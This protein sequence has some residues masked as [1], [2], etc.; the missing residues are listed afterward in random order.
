M[1]VSEKDLEAYRATCRRRDA[2]ERR[3]QREARQAGGEAAR[4]AAALLREQFG[5]ERVVLFGSLAREEPLGPRSDVD[6]AVEGLSTD[7][8]Y[9]A[10]AHTQ[11]VAGEWTVDLV[12]LERCDSSLRERIKQEGIAL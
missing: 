3:R 9:Q 1:A 5:A 12:R 2:E 8:Y 10:V 7:T 4:R 11:R 6:L